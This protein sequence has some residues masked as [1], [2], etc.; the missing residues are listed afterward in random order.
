MRDGKFQIWGMVT[1]STDSTSALIVG[2]LVIDSN[3]NPAIKLESIQIGTQTIPGVLVSQ[4]ESWLNQ[5]LL[6]K[7]EEQAPGLEIM[8]INVSNGLVTISGM[9]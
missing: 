4:M 3:K 8:N 2:N 6:E 7:I 9:R 1:G 5:M